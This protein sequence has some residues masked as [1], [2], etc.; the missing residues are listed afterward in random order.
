VPHLRVLGVPQATLISSSS[1]RPLVDLPLLPELTSLTLSSASCKEYSTE[2]DRF[3][4]LREF[5]FH[6]FLPPMR[7]TW[8]GHLSVFGQHLTVVHIDFNISATYLQG[9]MN[10]ISRYCSNLARLTLS[11][12]LWEQF[13]GGLCL[14][15]VP[16]L[17]L[18]CWQYQA[19]S[20]TYRWLL[21]NLS[22][23]SGPTLQTVRLC[24]HHN[25]TDLRLRHAKILAKGLEQ[26]L[27]CTFRLEDHEGQLFI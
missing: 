2:D 11:L 27:R 4:S 1:T 16:Y 14:P 7:D 18:R 20:P 19:T 26:I 12:K 3:P 5:E 9:E 8:E 6:Y 13:I 10:I 23:M 22:T 24:D 25:V 17:A 21:A 15:S